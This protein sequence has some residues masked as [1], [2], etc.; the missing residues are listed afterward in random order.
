MTSTTLHLALL[1]ATVMFTVANGDVFARDNNNQN[2]SNNTTINNQGGQGGQGGR[3]GDGGTGIGFGGTGIGFGGTGIGLGGNAV[4]GAAA[5]SNATSVSNASSSSMSNANALSRQRQNQRQGQG[6]VQ[7]IA[8]SGNATINN[9][10]PAHTTNETRFSGSYT[11]R[12]TP[13]V[14]APSIAGGANPCVIGV[15]GGG[16]VAGFGI[17]FG[18]TRNDEGCERRN[19]AALL[20]NMGEREVAQEV[21]CET[22]SVR[23]ARLRANRPCYVDRVEAART[24]TQATTQSQQ[25]SNVTSVVA[26]STNVATTRRV[27]SGIFPEYNDFS[28]GN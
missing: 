27:G 19:I 1:A 3:G 15:S 16:A 22:E 17:S 9:N 28:G 20:H 4:S 26:T 8:N 13:D 18:M 21:L 14:Y 23:Q 6:Q 12:N 24:A 25:M 7:G 5:V 2:N 10:V 11:V